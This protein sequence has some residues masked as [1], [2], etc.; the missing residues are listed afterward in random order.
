MGARFAILNAPRATSA[1]ATVDSA[2]R[3]LLT[4]YG[5]VYWAM[6]E[7][8]GVTAVAVASA[9]GT[10][11]GSISSA[12]PG[13]DAGEALGLAYLFDGINDHVNIYTAALNTLLSR[14]QGALMG[15]CKVSGAGIWTDGANHFMARLYIDANNHVQMLKTTT[16]SQISW[17][18]NAGGTT[19]TVMKNDASSTDWMHW[20]ITWD[21]TAD[22]VKA[23]YN[24]AQVGTTQTSLGTMTGNLD[25]TR[26]IIGAGVTS[27]AN[28]WSGYITH[29]CVLLDAPTDAE[30]LNVA[31]LGG[32]A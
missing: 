17:V 29:I 7:A 15:F 4:R 23:Y 21:K 10:Y 9:A 11:D 28:N 2:I 20:A 27:N 31:T 14:S 30:L 3:D 24:G 1:V 12:T 18:W 32:V 13:Q 19:E 22:A 25:A 8:S 16:N 5:G 6:Q 26:T